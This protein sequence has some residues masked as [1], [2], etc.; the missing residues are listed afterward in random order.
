MT[1]LGERSGTFRTNDGVDLYYE[2]AGTGR[3]VILIPGAACTMV[4]WKR[5]FAPLAEQL[6]VVAVDMRGFGRS[7]PSSWGQTCA[8]YATD[9]RGLIEHLDLS[10]VTLV[11][12]SCGARTIYTYLMLLGNQQLRGAVLVD[13]TVHHTVHDP[14]KAGDEQQPGESDL[15]YKQRW[16]RQMVSPVDPAAVPDAELDWMLAAIGAG[17]EMLGA[18]GQAQDFRPLCPQIDLPVL[19]ASGRHSGA[20]PGC[21]YAAEHIPGARLEIFEE[22]QHALFYTEAEKFN[23]LVV[24]FVNRP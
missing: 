4:W 2:E 6:H 16:L 12:W 14:P 15:A 23:R 5:N 3:A 10:A 22:S 7:G 1:D 24:D 19:L 13:D 11:G 18:D 21:R 8:R 17:P 9:I 20:L